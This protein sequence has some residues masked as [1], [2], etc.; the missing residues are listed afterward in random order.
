[1]QIPLRLDRNADTLINI[2]PALLSNVTTPLQQ[3]QRVFAA[4]RGVLR[5]VEA[6]RAG[7]HPR[8]LY[9]LRDE[10]TVEQV[11]AWTVPPH[12]SSCVR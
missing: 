4:H 12:D 8:T 3:A 7:I 10:G 6:Q 1:M 9:A 2:W 11:G 5:T